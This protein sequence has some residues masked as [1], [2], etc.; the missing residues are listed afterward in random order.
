MVSPTLFSTRVLLGSSVMRTG[1]SKN[2][3]G[4]FST[5]FE[6]LGRLNQKVKKISNQAT[7]DPEGLFTNEATGFPDHYKGIVEEVEFEPKSGPQ[8]KPAIII[9]TRATWPKEY[10]KNQKLFL[11]LKSRDDK[12]P[13]N[14]QTYL[15]AFLAMLHK[16]GFPMKAGANI[17]E[18]LK[19]LEGNQIECKQ[20][21][22]SQIAPK[23]TSKTK[24]MIVGYT[25][26]KPT[27]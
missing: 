13:A 9:N 15:G 10:E 7:I 4:S 20:I 24:W 2:L 14:Q 8:K 6:E 17:Y 5:I 12:F 23:I 26:L 25:T 3:P 19:S 1:S 18:T 22:G 11:G 27:A 16:T 21:P